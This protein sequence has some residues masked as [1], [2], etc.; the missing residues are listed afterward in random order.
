[1]FARSWTYIN[2][3]FFQ[4]YEK[5]HYY[6]RQNPVPIL[7]SAAALADDVSVPFWDHWD[8]FAT[9]WPQQNLP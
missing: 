6:E 1:M 4:I 5:L 9:G 3:L 7:Q 2:L 8:R